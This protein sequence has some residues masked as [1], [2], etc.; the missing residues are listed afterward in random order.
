[1][2]L[3]H[4]LPVCTRG[5]FFWSAC[6]VVWFAV[7]FYLSHGDKIPDAGLEI[8]HLD[9]VAH[10]GYFF[11]GGGLLAAALFFR[12][13]SMPW[14]RLILIVTVVLSLVGVFD[15]WHQSW[16]ESRTGNDVFDWLADTLGAFCGAVVFR[17]VHGILLPPQSLAAR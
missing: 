3:S 14:S 7:L 1:M 2:N 15:E 13:R 5:A 6:V 4:R 11:G 17:K 12:E 8:P 9:K 10:F 16:F